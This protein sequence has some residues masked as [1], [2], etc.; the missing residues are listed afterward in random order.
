MLNKVILNGR[1]TGDL[2]IKTTQSQTSYCQFNLAVQDDYVSKTT[3]ERG[4]NFISCV[5]FESTAKFIEQY[6]KK[7]DGIIVIG[8]IKTS[9]VDVD[10]NKKHYTKVIVKE[11]SFAISNKKE[12]SEKTLN[13]DEI[14]FEDFD[15]VLSEENF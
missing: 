10:G 3:N 8:S 2:E 6:F 15:E 4:V 13:L 12:E 9:T 11:I 14:D 1:I 5:A 7:G